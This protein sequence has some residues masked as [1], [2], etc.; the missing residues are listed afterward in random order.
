MERRSVVLSLTMQLYFARHAESFN[1]GLEGHANYYTRRKAEPELTDRG[2]AQ[3]EC[4]AGLVVGDTERHT[5][6]RRHRLS[7]N[8]W[9]HEGFDITHLYCSLQRRAVETAAV[10]AEALDRDPIAWPDI[11]ECGGVVEYDSANREFHG[12]TGAA[13]SDLAAWSP[14]LIIDDTVDPAGWW[15]DRTMESRDGSADR[16]DRV[17]RRL[18][19]SHGGTDDRVLLVSHSMFY[20]FFICRVLNLP[21]TNELWFTLNNA[22]L[23]RLDIGDGDDYEPG[24]DAGWQ[25]LPGLPV[26][27]TYLNRLDHL[28]VELVS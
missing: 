27:V 21:Y 4:L 18:L 3:A 5:H 8:P 7:R 14:R 10:V 22:A 19:E 20:V 2:R 9:N 25:K 26:R 16:A 1:N 13:A 24:M 6:A 23:T 11:H 28:P 17:Y 15:G 12:T